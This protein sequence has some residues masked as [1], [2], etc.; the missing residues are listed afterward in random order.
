MRLELVEA[1]TMPA[2]TGRS[3]RPEPC[4]DIWWPSCRY[5]GRKNTTA[6]RHDANIAT[7]ITEIR[8]VRSCR[9]STGRNGAGRGGAGPRARAPRKAMP[10][11]REPEKRAQRADREEHVPRQIGAARGRRMLLALRQPAKAPRREHREGQV[12]EEEPP[13]ARVRHHEAAHHRTGDARGG[14]DQ[15]EVALEARALARRDQLA[16][17]RLTQR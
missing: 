15:R 8:T 17:E 2:V 10:A 3:S 13:P 1:I 5:T 14:E 11:R 9:S 12:G 7:T 16:D 4:A 6:K